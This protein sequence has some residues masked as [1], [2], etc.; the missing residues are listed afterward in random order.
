[1]LN[2]VESSS[3]QSKYSYIYENTEHALLQI[4]ALPHPHKAWGVNLSYGDVY[5]QDGIQD[6]GGETPH[7]QDP[8]VQGAGGGEETPHLQDPHVQDPHVWDGDE[9]GT[10]E[11]DFLFF[12]TPK[13]DPNLSLLEYC[14]DKELDLNVSPIAMDGGR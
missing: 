13:W 11:P 3:D 4:S 8:H 12:N 10:D 7:V 14:R 1:M 5:L 9:V 6:G 2:G